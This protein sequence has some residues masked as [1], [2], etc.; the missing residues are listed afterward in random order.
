VAEG[1]RDPVVF[2]FDEVID[3]RSGGGLDRLV[4]LSPVP[5]R[6]EINWRRQAIA[7]RPDGGWRP[8]TTYHVTLLPGVADLRGNRL[9]TGKTVVF[10]TGGPVPSSAMTVTVVDWEAGRLVPRGLLLAILLPDSLVYVAVADSS[11]SVHLG[12]VPP[13]RYHVTALA[14]G[15]NNRRRDGREP[16]DSVTLELDSLVE[17]VFWTFRQDTLGPTI[18][19]AT[20]VDSQAVRLEF[21]QA[22]PPTAP[23]SATVQVLTLPDSQPVGLRALWSPVQYDSA[24]G[25]RRG[26][27]DS[28]TADTVVPSPEPPGVVPPG[29]PI[30]Q[31]AAAPPGAGRAAARGLQPAAPD[32]G[33]AAAVLAQRPRPL[34]GLIVELETP[35]TPGSRYVVVAEV[36]NLAGAQNRS[37][38][39]LIVPERSAGPP[40]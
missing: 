1:L 14:D 24:R 12:A 18:S 15:N 26:P 31:P 9:T 34:S 7:V 11:G 37:R 20:L 40:Q 32:T 6:T 30:P 28:V 36:A 5:E 39:V 21:S 35:L 33:R 10:T 27:A 3:E 19:R 17:R 16:F 8:G 2:R 22:L 25:T 4:L 29:P 13:G 38:T 23:E